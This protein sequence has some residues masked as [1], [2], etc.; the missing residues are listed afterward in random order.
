MAQWVRHSLNKI[1][2]LSSKLPKACK[3]QT[4]CVYGP[5]AP[6]TKWGTE[7]G[8]SQKLWGWLVW[9]TRQATQKSPPETSWKVRIVREVV[10]WPP[11]VQHGPTHKIQIS[12][13]HSTHITHT[14][15]GFFLKPL[16][17]LHGLCEPQKTGS[18]SILSQ[19]QAQGQSTCSSRWR[20]LLPLKFFFPVVT[21]FYLATAALCHRFQCDELWFLL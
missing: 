7:A 5:S 1:E 3:G 2:A 18:V 21:L 8:W 20:S 16:N 10:L 15:K 12:H 4:P 9:C 13:A 17:T 11:H 14:T 19:A 6:V